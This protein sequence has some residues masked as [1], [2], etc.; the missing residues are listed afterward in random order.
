MI[1][2]T[3]QHPTK[4]TSDSEVVIPELYAKCLDFFAAKMDFEASRAAAKPKPTVLFTITAAETSL[5][6]V[7]FVVC[8]EK[9]KQ[10][11]VNPR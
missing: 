5:V 3:L 10:S 4:Q 6:S 8:G 11:R 9:Y 2:D 1:K 7:L